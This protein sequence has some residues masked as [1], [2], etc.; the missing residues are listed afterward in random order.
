MHDRD[1]LVHDRDIVAAIMACDVTGVAAAFDRYAQ[2]LYA[3]CLSRLTE[4]AAAADAVQDTFVIAS[5]K[6]S[7]LSQARPAAGVAVRRG[8]Q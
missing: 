2:G 1:A 4:P 7:G 5:S 6:V 8:P 3:Y